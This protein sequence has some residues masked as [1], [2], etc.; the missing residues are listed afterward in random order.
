MSFQCG[1]E[2][3]RDIGHD[4]LDFVD[5]VGDHPA[6]KSKHSLSHVNPRVPYV[7]PSQTDVPLGTSFWH[8]PLVGIRGHHISIS[9]G[10]ITLIGLIPRPHSPPAKSQKPGRRYRS[11]GGSSLACPIVLSQII[12]VYQRAMYTD[13]TRHDQ[14]VPWQS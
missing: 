1:V 8:H 2:Y 6:C 5:T 11:S 9:F 3:R 12:S 13:G 7:A 10:I 14:T 4:V